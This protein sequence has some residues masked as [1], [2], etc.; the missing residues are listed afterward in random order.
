MAY[1]QGTVKKST[2][3][4][5]MPPQSPKAGPKVV[6]GKPSSI[7]QV[8]SHE[9]G[10]VLMK[11]VGDGDGGDGKRVRLTPKEPSYPPPGFVGT[12]SS[13]GEITKDDAM[14]F[15]SGGLATVL[16]NH[17]IVFGR[18]PDVQTVKKQDTEVGQI[19]TKVVGVY[20]KVGYGND[21]PLNKSEEVGGLSAL[22]P[23]VCAYL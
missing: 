3:P 18:K 7:S 5:Q 10:N 16:D 9:P 20:H 1:K 22:S 8:T 13:T 21:M 11:V 12:S 23:N 6:A 4:A 19:I 17:T 15:S 14:S 2:P